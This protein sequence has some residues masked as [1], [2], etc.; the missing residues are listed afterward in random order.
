MSRDPLLETRWR[1]NSD[2]TEWL[3]RTVWQ[4]MVFLRTPEGPAFSDD[5]PTRDE[6]FEEYERIEEATL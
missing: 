4:D 2:G 6:L 1:R 5:C 3:V